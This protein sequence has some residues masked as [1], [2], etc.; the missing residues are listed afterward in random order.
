METS[1][2]WYVLLNSAI[3]ILSISW[4][5]SGLFGASWVPTSLNMVDRM[6]KLAGLKKAKPC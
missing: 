5:L 3:I 4:A 6:L 1:I 2:P